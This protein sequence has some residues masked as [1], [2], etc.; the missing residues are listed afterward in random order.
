MEIAMETKYLIIGSSHAGLSAADEIRLNDPEGSLAMVSMEDCLPY[1][2]TVLPYIV[3]GK[4][5]AGIICL[6][7]DQYF[8]DQ[9]IT[10]RRG[11]KVVKVDTQASKVT[12]DDGSEVGYEKLLIA[13]GSEPTLPPIPGLKEAKVYVLRTM[14]DAQ[15]IN[16]AADQAKTAVI[17]GT[18]LVG[19]H[20]AEGLAEKG[21]KVEV[22]RGRRPAVLP[23][24][25]DKVSM[26]MIHK[27]FLDHGIGCNLDNQVASIEP[28]EGE[29][30]KVMLKNGNAIDTDM[31]VVGTGVRSRM[32]FFINGSPKMEEG[33]LVDETMRT[34]VGNVW[35]AGDVAQ[36]VDFFSAKKELNAILPDAFE[37][38][39]IAGMSMAGNLKAIEGIADLG[40]REGFFYN[41]GV[42]MNTFNFYGNRSFAVGLSLVEDDGECAIHVS[43]DID[44]CFYQKFVFKGD[45]LVGAIGINTSLDPGVL[46]NIIRRKVNM[47]SK[48]EN[49]VQDPQNV[50]RRIMWDS[51][52]GTSKI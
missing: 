8:A 9:N 26:Q 18:G 19:M 12:L 21:L 51:W 46:M 48:V 14:Q 40:K 34:S 52:R 41:G 22:I 35:A 13:T 27:V 43:F 32:D 33:I 10:F 36:A 25:F 1:S 5:D 2:P 23:N 16:K 44:R 11:K 30:A 49:F 38:G 15:E 47:K 50:S 28:G 39:K 37:Q 3:S 24:Y 31:L 7:D 29:K 4:V 17:L 20:A 6:R 45:Y 42:S